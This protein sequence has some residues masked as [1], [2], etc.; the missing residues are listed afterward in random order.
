MTKAESSPDATAEESRQGIAFHS[1][2]TGLQGSVF[3]SH[4]LREVLQQK[5]G[6]GSYAT[7]GRYTVAAILNARSGRTPFLEE[8]TIVRMWNDLMSQG[9]YEPLAGVQWG[10]SEILDY[11]KATMR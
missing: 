9:H 2:T 10:A 5:A 3:G 11:F 8:S 4:T 1:A 6:G 7:L